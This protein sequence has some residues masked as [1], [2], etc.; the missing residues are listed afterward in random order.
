MGQWQSSQ[1]SHTGPAPSDTHT[2][3]KKDPY[4]AKPSGSCCLKGTIHE[5]EP[6]G[7]WETIA[8]VETY[9]STPPEGKANGNVLLYFP[10]VWGMFTNGLLVMDAFADAGYTV[11]GLDYFRGDPVWKHRKNRHDNSN[12]DFDYEAWKRK[13]TA[14]ANEAVP[15]WVS[16]VASRYRQVNPETK[17]ACVG[18]CFGAPYVCDELAKETVAAGAFAHPAFLKEHHFRNI[19]KP[20][21]LSCS[22]VD[23]TFDVP[24]RRRALDILQQEGKVYHYQLF[25]GVEHGFALRGDPND[26]Y[27]RYNFV[28]WGSSTIR[29]RASPV[30]KIFGLRVRWR[31]IRLLPNLRVLPMAPPR[32]FDFAG[33]V[34]IVTGAGSRMDGEIGNGRASAILLARHGAKVALLDYNVAWANETKRMIDEEGGI[35][36]VIQAD[37]TDEESCKAAVAKTVELFGAV[38]ILV[39][40]VGVGGAMGDATVVN[41]DA[42]DRDFRINVTSMVLMSR[43]AIPEM[44]KQGR[45]AIVNMSSVSGLLGGNPSLLYPTTKGAIIQMTRAMAAQHGRENIRV[46]CVCPGMVYTP[47]T[48]GR[49]MT[50]EM[51]QARINQNLMKLEGTGWDVGYAVLFLSSKEARWITGLIMPV[52]GGVSNT[53][54]ETQAITVRRMVLTDRCRPQPGEPTDPR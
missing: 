52:D 22:E 31:R 11:L 28:G 30:L 23:H 47:M 49:G 35:S 29:P 20:L 24:S 2:H 6:R 44:R 19:K 25:S 36:E 40:N 38:H 33:D 42:W 39:N 41:L 46:N 9:I 32:A 27:Q 37:V 15:K 34:A 43:Y 17:F 12:P 21:F 18:Y 7:T 45:G 16:C 13:H 5:G 50:P 1:P 53:T 48:R 26:P 8:G 51:R 4:L 10:D 54:R 3:E 14:F